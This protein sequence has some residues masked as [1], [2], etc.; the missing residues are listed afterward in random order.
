MDSL[1]QLQ[2]KNVEVI[3]QGIV[4]K[5]KLLGAGEAEVYLQTPSGRVTLPM[6]GITTVR[7]LPSR[8]G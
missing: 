2:G 6:S 8:K 4:Y 5:G 1:Q 3:Y 7:A